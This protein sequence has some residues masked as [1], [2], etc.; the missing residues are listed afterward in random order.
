[1]KK[2][3]VALDASPAARAVLDQAVAIARATGARLLLFRAVSLPVE[4]PAEVLLEGAAVEGVLLSRARAELQRLTVSVPV[5][6]LGGTEVV[7]GMP[8]QAICEAARR[9]EVDLVVI[10]SHGYGGWDRILGT[11][12]ARV[13]NHADRSVL[14]VKSAKPK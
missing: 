12:A 5:D 10:G 7:I 4:L 3:L 9:D 11:T 6:L 13:V 8:W 1:M 14:V 2:I